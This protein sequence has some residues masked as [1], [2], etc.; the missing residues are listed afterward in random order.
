VTIKIT[1]YRT[2]LNKKWWRWAAGRVIKAMHLLLLLPAAV[3]GLT[4]NGSLLF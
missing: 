3:G 4:E 1:D 2:R